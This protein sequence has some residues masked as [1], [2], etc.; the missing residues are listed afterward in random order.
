MY[1]KI[2]KDGYTINTAWGVKTFDS[3][4]AAKAFIDGHA[5]LIPENDNEEQ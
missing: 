5:H 1:F 4:L 2:S 3:Y